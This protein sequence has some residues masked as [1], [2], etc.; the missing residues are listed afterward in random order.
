MVIPRTSEYDFVGKED[1]FRS[2]QVK[3]KSLGVDLSPVGM[4]SSIKEEKCGHGYMHLERIPHEG[5]DLY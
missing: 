2:N 5:E 1:L 4:V 3:M